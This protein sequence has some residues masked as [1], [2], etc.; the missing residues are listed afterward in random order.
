MWCPDL[1]RLALG[2]T[3]CILLGLMS[4]DRYVAICKPLHYPHLMNW[5][6][7]RQMAVSS[8]ASGTFNALIHTAYT[9]QLTFYGSREI[10]HFY[11][12][13]PGSCI[14]P[15]RIPRPMT[16]GFWS[17]P[18]FCF[19][20]HSQPSLSHTHSSWSPSFK[21]L[22]LRDEKKHSQ[23]AHLTWKWSAYIMVPSFSCI[24]SQSLLI[25]QAKIKL[26]LSSIPFWH[27][28]LTPWFIVFEI[29]MWWEPWKKFYGIGHYIIKCEYK[30][31]MDIILLSINIVYTIWCILDYMI[32]I[33]Y[34]SMRWSVAFNFLT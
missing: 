1:P 24:C 21:W 4:Y 20:F 11:C 34:L 25:L 30:G 31:S 5:P 6:L 18:R 29:R 22:L 32:T 19:W 9:M 17:P 8:W 27:Q 3:E 12:E 15:V 26:Y 33:T 23:P 14:S 10:N 28:C 16:L 13:L 7:C 2:G